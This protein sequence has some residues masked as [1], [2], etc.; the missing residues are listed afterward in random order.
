LYHPRQQRW[1]DH[2]SWNEDFAF[3]IGITKIGRV[4]VEALQLNREGL[5]N[6]RRVLYLVNEHPPYNK[7]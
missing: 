6:L 3:I 5:V 1:S 7:D 4:T 2:F